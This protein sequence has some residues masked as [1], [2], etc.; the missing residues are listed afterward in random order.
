MSAFL[1]RFGVKFQIGL[2][3]ALG[4]IGFAVATLV[5]M[6]GVRRIEATSNALERLSA[7]E[8]AAA[9]AARDLADARIVDTRFLMAPSDALVARHAHD[10]AE[11]ARALDSLAR[12]PGA[13]AARLARLDEVATA[14]GARFA[15]LVALQRRLG[16]SESEGL[17]GALREAV[18]GVEERLKSFGD[19]ELQVLMLMMRRHEKDFIMRGGARY[20]EA[21][22][23]RRGEFE[24]LLAGRASLPAADRRAI[25]ELMTTYGA[26][27]DAFAAAQEEAGAVAAALAALYA[28]AEPAIA[29]MLD[30]IGAAYEAGLAALVAQ[31]AA[32]ERTAWIAA[33]LILTLLLAGSW[34]VGRSLANPL[35]ALSDA[36]ARLAGGD[37]AVVVPG[38]G[39]RDELGAMA[40]AL[41]GFKAALARNAEMEAEAKTRERAEAAERARLLASLAQDFEEQVGGIV[42][43]VAETA[44][45]LNGSADALT[46]TAQATA[47]QASAAAAASEQAAANVGT[48]AAAAEELASSTAEIGRQVSESTAMAG[49][50]TRQ[51]T[52]AVTQV[53]GTAE[54]AQ[55]IGDIVALI[56][57]IAEQTNLLA[58]N[59]T[60]E[61]ARAGEAGRGFAVVAAE[62][63]RLADQTS[64][65]TVDIGRQVEGI[66]SATAGSA[67][68]IAQ[69]ARVVE[70]L[71][72]T[73]TAIAAAVEQQGAATQEIARNVQQASAGT[74]EVSR[75]IA[76][77]TD[78]AGTASASASEVLRSSSDLSSRA[79]E[80]TRAVRGFVEAVTRDGAKAA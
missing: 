27:F 10:V 80:L 69:I 49:D 34:L 50:A 61:A 20:V 4:V 32:V 8:L 55:R 18:H 6:D 44:R 63:K 28:E 52:G 16:Y 40:R 78:A 24:A 35:V 56:Q 72:A 67:E 19:A 60:I 7:R 1:S 5:F 70:G 15:D 37:V 12:E 38:T 42:A 30:E 58:L 2:L 76:G 25:S 66:Q 43:T 33:G 47:V 23:T 36:L 17:Q 46:T 11:A 41:D 57:E 74:A 26:A 53:R 75:G 13:I 68:A 39:R 3:A 29:A 14:Y 22:Q 71:S 21:H 31:E 77:V 45:G 48:V 64:K 73:S 9:S 65:A 79:D 51:A 54:A 62:V 59:A